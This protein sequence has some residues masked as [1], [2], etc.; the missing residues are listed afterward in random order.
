MAFPGVFCWS[1]LLWAF[2]DRRQCDEI[3]NQSVAPG[4]RNLRRGSEYRRPR[5]YAAAQQSRAPRAKS[6][7]VQ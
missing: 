5:D 1:L 4:Q 6:A 2:R 3:M 7:K